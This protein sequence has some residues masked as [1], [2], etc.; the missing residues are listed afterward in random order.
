MLEIGLVDGPG[1]HFW[2]NSRRQLA[3][4]ITHGT[5]E[6]IELLSVHPPAK[7]STDIS[8]FQSKFNVV[9]FVDRRI[10]ATC[11][12]G[13]SGLSSRG[14]TYPDHCEEDTDGAKNGLGWCD[15]RGLLCEIQSLDGYIQ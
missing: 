8:A 15:A 3:Y 9:Q 7:R 11:K 5:T 14:E 12:H 4:R 10:L 1:V 13:T 6:L 2:F